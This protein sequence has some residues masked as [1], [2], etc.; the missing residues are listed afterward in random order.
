MVRR[1]KKGKYIV[2]NKAGR[3]IL[4]TSDK[5]LADNYMKRKEDGSNTE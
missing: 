2:Y 1:N 5:R 4:I 3:I